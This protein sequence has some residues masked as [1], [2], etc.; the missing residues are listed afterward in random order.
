VT[1]LVGEGADVDMMIISHSDGDHIGD[2]G[3]IIEMVNLA[4]FID[5][6]DERPDGT[7]WRRMMDALD[8][9]GAEVWHLSETALEPG[10]YYELG[11][12]TLTL[13]AGWPEWIATS[14]DEAERHNAI[15][16]VAKL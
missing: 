14:L 1:E 9:E 3:A 6:G 4:S 10:T 15:S 16:I 12:A 5:T 2:A 8:E 13:I 7:V 11:D